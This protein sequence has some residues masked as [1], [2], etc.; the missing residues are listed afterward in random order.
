MTRRLTLRVG[1]ALCT[2]GPLAGCSVYGLATALGSLTNTST[3]VS[4]VANNRLL[5]LSGLVRVPDALSANGQVSTLP[6]LTTVTPLLAVAPL[7]GVH[8]YAT[9][10]VRAAQSTDFGPG[11]LRSAPIEF[12]DMV[13]GAIAATTSTDLN[14]RYVAQLVF[15]GTQHPFMAETLLRNPFNQVVGF[16]AAPIGADVS[17]PSGKHATVD[18]SPA[19]TMVAFS[20]S[21]L[22]ESYPTFDPRF[23]FTGVKSARLAAMIGTISPSSL[24]AAATMLDQSRTLSEATTFDGLLSD[25]ATA[26]AVLTY[27]VKKLAAQALATD[28]LTVESPGLN[29]AILGQMVARISALTTPVPGGAQGFF[30]TV[31]GTVNLDLAKGQGGPISAAL[32][33][34]PPLPTPTPA[35]GVNVVFQ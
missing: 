15:A 27:E 2:L 18:L 5:E 11:I 28:S 32:P 20:A 4:G 9:S 3:Q 12:V 25:T 17:T 29:A 7:A 22:S 14:G 26:S 33:N 23:G 24:Q 31:A 1:L 16:L 35:Q 30:D 34:L 6:P 13:T 21:L 8:L 10:A 19:T